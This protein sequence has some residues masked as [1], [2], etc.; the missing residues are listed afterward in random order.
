[1]LLSLLSCLDC[2]THH[3][4]PAP[5]SFYRTFELFILPSMESRLILGGRPRVPH[6]TQRHTRGE[7]AATVTMAGSSDERERH[8]SIKSMPYEP[9]FLTDNPASSLSLP[10]NRWRRL[11]VGK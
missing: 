1:M 5:S 10:C 3:H 7:R 11:G 9:S 2:K 8:S 6:Y 4:G